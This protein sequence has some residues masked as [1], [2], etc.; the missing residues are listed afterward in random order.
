MDIHIEIE[1][2]IDRLKEQL[3]NYE[4]I[5][6]M[7]REDEIK[8]LQN[9]T[10]FI[11]A[12]LE[13]CLNTLITRAIFQPMIEYVKLRSKKTLSSVASDM[14]LDEMDF[15][16]KIDLSKRLG[17]LSKKEFIS[18]LYKVN[19]YRKWFSHPKTYNS[20]ITEFRDR[21]KHLE[22]LETLIDS[23]NEMNLIFEKI[24]KL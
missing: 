3:Q 20:R 6:P 12:R 5:D 17:T 1:N 18:K 11:H 16:K 22:V 15:A 24:G 9:R 8:D 19:E 13:A 21:S 23:Y 2:K 7:Y 4:D 14:V 10:L